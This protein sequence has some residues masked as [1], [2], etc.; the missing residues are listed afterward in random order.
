V[1]YSAVLFRRNLFAGAVACCLW[2]SSFEAFAG[3]NRFDESQ[4]L[5]LPTVG[6][7][8]LRIISP[9]LLELVLVNTKERDPARVSSWDFVTEKFTTRLP[10]ASDFK[11][12]VDGREA[13]VKQ[14]GF[15]RRTLYA[16]LKKR[17]MRIGNHLYLELQA[18][19]RE[20]Q[21]VA[22]QN[23]KGA[24]WSDKA[25]QFEARCE[26]MRWS[27]AVHVNQVGYMP[28]FPKKAM[29]GF[30]MGTMGEMTLAQWSKAQAPAF[31]VVDAESGKEMFTGT[32]RTRADR[33]FTFPTYQ[34]VWE[35]DFSGF[36]QPGR[37]RLLVPG[38]GASFPFWIDEGIAAAA[39]RSYALGLYHQRC[40]TSND[41]P[42]T[43]FIHG[44]C[45]TAPA[46]VPGAGFKATDHLIK[47]MSDGAT[48][49]KR[50]TAVQL[51]SVQTSLYPIVRQG[52]VD[53]SGGHHDAG[54]YSKYT[55]NSA[56]LIHALVFAADAFPGV[57][58]LDNLGLPESGDGKSDLLQEAKWEADFLAKMQDKDGGF[59]FLVY[60]KER[61]Y[62]DDVPPDKGD[63]QVVWPKNTSATAAAVAALAQLS[64]S[65]LFRKQFPAAATNY[66]RHAKLGWVFLENALVKHGRDGAYQK[67]SH[68]GHEFL[69]DD[70][71]A[72]AATEM[73]LATGDPAFERQ[74][75]SQFDPTDRETKRW[76]WWRLYEAYGCAVRS[77]AFA[78]LTGRIKP[79][80][81]NPEHLRKCREE[82]AAAGRDQI[83]FAEECAYGSSFPDPN[84]RFRNAGWYFSNDQ[85]FDIAVAW[86]LAASQGPTQKPKSTFQNS[87][88]AVFLEAM[89]SNWNYE[90]GCNPVNVTYLTG[91]G[92]KRPR[93]IVHQFAQNDRR[94]LPPSG[95]PI[96]NIQAGFQF[97]HHYEKELGT[98]TFPPDG[99]EQSPYPF[100]DRWGDS[101]NVTTEFVIG[102]QGRGLAAV[103]F[104][105]A[106][107]SLKQQ[108]WSS[109]KLEISGVP[110]KAMPG[111]A[112]TAAAKL[113]SGKDLNL[114]RALLVWEAEGHEPMVGKSI[115][116]QPKGAGPQWIEV[117]A[118]WPDGRRA[119]AVTNYVAE[120][121]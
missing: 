96:G 75:L 37:Y 45:H 32:L 13:P 68:Y 89:L 58:D 44:P 116:I 21:T 55:I 40:G 67:I 2:L 29:V 46:E 70:E 74:V 48:Q 72:W 6:S 64:S 51:Q 76:T 88:D 26:P 42:F 20:G 101:F 106:R 113:V 23:P 121:R 59:H 10:A 82:I 25:M 86:Q 38:L 36:K 112:F 41:L 91:L 22:V 16:P 9:T 28:Q 31:R 56:A 14:V 111:Q 83:R 109:A 98:V 100:Y 1:L 27:P 53:V 62:E 99:V 104:L 79:E 35:A 34:Q 114:D 60:P 93:D 24:L 108:P 12:M 120:A 30:Y 110:A 103:A 19:M 7:H 97:L 39:T 105:M 87:Q 3:T 49:D 78:G 85:A 102:N 117:E 80:R 119:F 43:R 73:F 17:D 115:K 54:D 84:K 94:L 92:W 71:L 11:V 90:A 15:K 47:G 63:P 61:A 8:A 77:Y 57:G 107:T 65:P 118:Q 66:L 50:H 4:P 52:K 95:I 33:G 5:W 69:H 81:L 18:P